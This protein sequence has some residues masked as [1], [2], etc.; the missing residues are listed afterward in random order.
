LKIVVLSCHLLQQPSS[1]KN[2]P[3]VPHRALPQLQPRTPLKKQDNSPCKWWV[4]WFFFIW[5]IIQ[6]ELSR[7]LAYFCN[8]PPLR[9]TY[10]TPHAA[11]SHGFNPEPPYR[12]RTIDCA[13]G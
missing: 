5:S 11:P 3:P 8:G 4:L 6:F 9:I 10:T 12:S 7:W 2:K 13:S 1:T